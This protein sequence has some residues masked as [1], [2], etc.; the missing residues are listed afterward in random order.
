MQQSSDKNSTIVVASA[1]IEMQLE[2]AIDM[3]LP[4]LGLSGFLLN[5]ARTYSSTSLTQL[6]HALHNILRTTGTFVHHVT[7][8]KVY[9]H[10]ILLAFVTDALIKRDIFIGAI[11]NNLVATVLLRDISELVYHSRSKLK[12]AVRFINYDILDV[13]NLAAPMNKLQLHEQRC[14]RY[15]FV[16]TLVDN[17]DCVISLGTSHHLPILSLKSFSVRRSNTRELP[18][19]LKKATIEVVLLQ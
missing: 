17:D 3:L 9:D 5:N 12:S 1:N 19:Q 15:Y 7:S 10:L 11:E 4:V 13:S 2:L 8:F 16:S 14:A 18:E 6:Y